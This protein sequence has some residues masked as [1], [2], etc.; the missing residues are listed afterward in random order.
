MK[1]LL[2]TVGII[3]G[4]TFT[5]RAQDTAKCPII[6]KSKS[7]KVQGLNYLRNRPIVSKPIDPKTNIDTI[8]KS[9]SDSTRFG[10]SWFVS[11]TGWVVGYEDGGPQSC[12][13]FTHDEDNQDL[14]LYIAKSLNSWKDSIFTVAVTPNYKKTHGI[15]PDSLFGQKVT[16]SG[17][18]LYDFENAKYSLNDCK[19]CNKAKIKTAW[20]IHP[21]VTIRKAPK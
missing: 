21:V 2:Y 19:N 13:C 15:E 7:I 8:L 1:T 10:S 16:I 5:L 3:V 14:V 9:G 17:Y 4:C 18:M 11:V 12:N 20:E 6:G